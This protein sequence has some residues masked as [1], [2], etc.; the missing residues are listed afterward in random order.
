MIRL[1]ALQG[2]VTINGADGAINSIKSIVEELG[3]GGV[4]L[5]DFE[6]G[7]QNISGSL[8]KLGN[9][10]TTKVTLPI[11]GAGTASFKMAADFTETLS[12]VDVV[13][14]QSADEVKAWGDTTLEQYGLAKSTSLEMVSYF[15]DMGTSMQLPQ[16]EAQNMAISLTELS[17]DMA[18]FKNISVDRAQTAL[19]AVYTG[20]TEALKS[21]GVVMTVANL[22]AYAM[23]E[24]ITKAYKDM[25]QAEQVTLRYNYV[26]QATSN[27]H[28]DF[29]RTSDSASN[30][31][32]ILLESLKELA[33]EFGDELIP[34]ILP[35][36]EQLRGLIQTFGE[37]EDWQKKLVVQGGLFAASLGPIAKGLSGLTT[38]VLNL[39]RAITFLTAHPIVAILTAVA[40][41]LVAVGLKVAELNAKVKTTTQL[42][43]QFGEMSSE[44]L[45]VIVDDTE[46][47]VA[48]YEELGEA[49]EDN[50]RKQEELER[51]NEN[52]AKQVNAGTITLEEYTNQY[53]ENKR[54][55]E[56][57]KDEYND[58]TRQHNKLND[59]IVEEYGSVEA[60]FE[61]RN[62]AIAWLGRQKEAEELLEM[63]TNQTKAEIAS[64]NYL[65]QNGS[66][67]TTE[68]VIADIATR[69][70]AMQAEMRAA[71]A[72]SAAYE[73][74][75]AEQIAAMGPVTQ[76]AIEGARVIGITAQSKIDMLSNYLTEVKG[77]HAEEARSFDDNAKEVGCSSRDKKQAL[78]DDT[79]VVQEELNK[80][81]DA[82]SEY[83]DELINK[84]QE[85]INILKA[86]KKEELDALKEEKNQRDDE[87]KLE[88][89]EKRL[90]KEEQAKIEAE[91]KAQ[92]KIDEV[93]KE[94][95]ETSDEKQRER[96]KK[97]LNDAEE[98]KVEATKRAEEKIIDAQDKIKEFHYE[99]E[100][101]ARVSAVEKQ[102][103]AE[104][105]I[106][107]T[108]M[109]NLKKVRDTHIDTITKVWEEEFKNSGKVC[110]ETFAK[111][112]NTALDAFL[113]KKLNVTVDISSNSKVDGSHRNGLDS[114]PFDG[115]LAEL[116]KGER[117][118]TESEADSYNQNQ[119]TN[120]DTSELENEIKELKEE[121]RS[122]N[123]TIER[124]PAEQQR[125]NRMG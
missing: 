91:R 119:S 77:L 83:M 92:E 10:L 97:R 114:V 33:L 27:A 50:A 121:I 67:G 66:T 72:V 6:K 37:M 113:K 20:E 22:E 116:H 57:L 29:A 24:G 56:E 51:T 84:K 110:G 96:L 85:E 71:A 65:I 25:T 28:G 95:E 103:E 62:E 104:I 75:S 55:A 68:K 94:L 111:E 12:K 58:L 107:E 47:T 100:Y 35:V 70:E 115:Y 61:V 34:V 80:Q 9:D 98:D 8:D 73:G 38:T 74:A 44:A 17:A 42:I 39:N 99:Q 1:G 21:L 123:K 87:K 14:K 46:N 43:G 52:L 41:A 3:R 19:A 88:E 53:N 63:A 76:N 11:V 54:K 26:M 124:L 122:I 90:E 105:K 117:V 81:L 16:L 109:N 49:I 32:R 108:E 101:N 15:G 48:A 102:Y 64:Y 118:L 18:S 69:I 30:Q 120:L 23:S 13:F 82:Y 125:L 7:L 106:A 79:K 59:A 112:F 31:I 45:Q 78:E 5:N 93:K 89:L 36:I 2:D 86:K 60:G 40:G 4:S